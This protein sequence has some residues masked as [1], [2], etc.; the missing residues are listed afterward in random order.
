MNFTPSAELLALQKK[1]L[2][3]LDVVID[4]CE[5]YNITYYMMH[6]SLIGVIR[7]EGIIPWDDDIDIAVMRKD[8]KRFFEACRKELPEPYFVQFFNTDKTYNVPHIKIRDS[9]TCAI[10][11]GEYNYLINHKGRDCKVNY[12]M[13]IFLDVF[14]LDGIPEDKML[15]KRYERKINICNF[16][17]HLAN[18]SK[19]D[20]R[21][22][23]GHIL[24]PFVRFFFLFC[25]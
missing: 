14:P 10:T 18:I 17:I 5:K 23:K 19:T 11:K 22:L 16:F 24:L 21:T 3:I 15:R 4:I 8:Y 9:S 2:E 13:G 1:E 7:H 6:G 20:I 25:S 12:N